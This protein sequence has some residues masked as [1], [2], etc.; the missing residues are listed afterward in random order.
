MN[1]PLS[2]NL[3]D[4]I[5]R[6]DLASFIQ[7]SFATVAPGQ[8]YLPNWHIEAIGWRLQEVL[9]G[10]N[11]RLIVAMPP[12]SLKSIAASV[13][14]PAFALGHDPS[15]RIV[16]ASYSVDLAIKHAND[17]RAV[18]RSAW[19]RRLFPATRIDSTK[20][21]EAEFATTR[22]GYRLSTSVGGTLTG[23]GGDLVI[24][25]DPLK[26]ADA[27][28]EPK[29]EAAN[30]WFSN[31]LL[32]RLDDKRSGAIV[33]VMQRVHQNDLVGHLL[34][35]NAS[36][37]TVLSLPAICEV[38]HA[39]QLDSRRSVR[40]PVGHVLH[41]AREPRAV[42]DAL[43]RELGSDLFAAQY[44]QSPVPPGGAMIR[45]AW[46]RYESNPTLFNYDERLIHSWDTATKA[47]DANDW[48]VCTIWRTRSDG[49]YLVD[50][51]RRRLE[52]H[53]LR[54]EAHR[55]ARRDQPAAI[56]IEDAG[57][58][59]ALIA[60]LRAENV[61]AIAIRPVADKI[62]RLSIVAPIF[63]SRRVVLNQHAVWLADLE[64]ELFS[65]PQSR[66]DDQVDSISQALAWLS[67]PRAEPRIRTL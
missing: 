50:V 9:A 67:R 20:D 28:S 23:R 54:K 60:D 15:R 46:L 27:W 66:H 51:F 17:C 33:V 6:T 64:A 26:A 5:V 35:R 37:W 29:R 2:A 65:F 58:G 4:A 45:R 7:K 41:E 44:L 24:I 10:R 25:D 38:E 49:Y 43:K 42:L 19:Y 13:A 3:L 59:S 8:A 40:R 39:V 63:E 31:T 52:Y 47:G 57:V 22:R 18:M 11:R 61:P 55:L 30:A 48:S 16:T 36:D 14:F 56:L 12:R 34:D 62:T 21:S 53:E 32:S 1:G